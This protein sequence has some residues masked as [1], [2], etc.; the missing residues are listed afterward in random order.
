MVL[1]TMAKETPASLDRERLDKAAM[2]IET[3]DMTV[4][5]LNKLRHR[6]SDP[7]FEGADDETLAIVTRVLTDIRA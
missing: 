6:H 3:L 2:A 1:R 5:A 4:E 7:N